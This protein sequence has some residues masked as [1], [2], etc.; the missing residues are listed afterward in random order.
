MKEVYICETC[1][2]RFPSSEECEEHEVLYSTLETRWYYKCGKNEEWDSND[3]WAFAHNKGWHHIDLCRLGYGSSLDGCEVNFMICDDCLLDIVKSFTVEGQE[4]VINSGSNAY[5]PTD[6]WIR[7]AKGELTDEEYEEYGMYSPR[8]LKAYEQRFPVCKNTYIRVYKDGSRGSTCNFHT[9]TWG[10][11]NGNVGLN[12]S[13][14][15]YGCKDFTKR[16]D[17]DQIP[18]VEI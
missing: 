7:K 9:C 11:E 15:C 13:T 17:G 4:K 2:M 14:E 8:Q 3:D 16:K 18:V 5:L 1:D 10:D 12:P 6:I